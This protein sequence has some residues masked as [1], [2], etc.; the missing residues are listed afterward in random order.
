MTQPSW[1]LLLLQG[2]AFLNSGLGS[3]GTATYIA[4]MVGED[5]V[6][7]MNKAKVAPCFCGS[8]DYVL[9]CREIQ[10]HGGVN[11]WT[12]WGKIDEKRGKIK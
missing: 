11:T 9:M 8:I 2:G 6:K 7:D 4:I 1:M 12:S 5:G 10:S 3:L